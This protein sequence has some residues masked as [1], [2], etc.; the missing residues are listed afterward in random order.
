MFVVYIL[1][2]KIARKSYV[3]FT[4]NIERRLREH[5]SGNHFYTKRYKPWEIIHKEEFENFEKAI[6]REKFLKSTSGRRF[7]KKLFNNIS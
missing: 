4:N 5:N 7:L 3:G 2:S 6:K 1:K